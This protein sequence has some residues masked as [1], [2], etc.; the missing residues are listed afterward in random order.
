MNDDQILLFFNRIDSKLDG[1]IERSASEVIRLNECR[2]E[3]ARLINEKI[4]KKADW[5]IMK[6]VFSGVGI[7]LAFLFLASL[8]IRNNISTIKTELSVHMGA[9]VKS[10]PI[11]IEGVV[12]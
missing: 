6:W 7:A 1:I 10:S 5:S 4:D 9:V 8:D 12:K 2:I 3:D 11:D